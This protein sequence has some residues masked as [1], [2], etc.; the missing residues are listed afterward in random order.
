MTKKFYN[1]LVY[2]SREDF[3]FDNPYSSMLYSNADQ[4]YVWAERLMDC[5]PHSTS[6]SFHADNGIKVYWLS[7]EDDG[8]RIR[9]K[10]R[11]GR[12]GTL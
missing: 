12:R 3:N 4:A 1:Y 8:T 6:V 10:Y 11:C 5:H 7:R 2:P 9:G